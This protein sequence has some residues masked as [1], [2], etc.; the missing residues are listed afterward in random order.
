MVGFVQN[1]FL[2]GLIRYLNVKV[3]GLQSNVLYSK[4]SE[5][6]SYITRKNSQFIHLYTKYVIRKTLKLTIRLEITGIRNSLLYKPFTSVSLLLQ[7][8]DNITLFKQ[9]IYSFAV[10]II[11]D[12]KNT[13]VA[14]DESFRG[15]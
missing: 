5:I 10:Y 7:S 14:T 15:N 9:K 13:W 6:S 4:F 2:D 3:K 8:R 1:S 11:D 12:E